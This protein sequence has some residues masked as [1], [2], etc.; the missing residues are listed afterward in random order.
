M[1]SQFSHLACIWLDR[2]GGVRQRHHT[3]RGYGGCG[4]GELKWWL[5]IGGVK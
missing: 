3:H 2:V 5:I 1:K 4:G